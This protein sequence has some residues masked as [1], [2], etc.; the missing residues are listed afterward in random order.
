MDF[1]EILPHL[2]HLEFIILHK[3][4]VYAHTPHILLNNLLKY[5][6]SQIQLVY[7]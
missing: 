5:H 4:T 1:D 2:K 3:T 6:T 7:T